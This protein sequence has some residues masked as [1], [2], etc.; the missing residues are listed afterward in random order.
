[1]LKILIALMLLL[2]IL[3]ISINIFC[4]RFIWG[5]LYTVFSNMT[6]TTLKCLTDFNETQIIFQK[7]KIL[8]TNPKSVENLHNLKNSQSLSKTETVNDEDE[9]IFFIATW[10]AKNRKFSQFSTFTSILLFHFYIS[11]KFYSFIH[12]CCNLDERSGKNYLEGNRRSFSYS[13]CW[14]LD[15][16]CS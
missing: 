16:K 9:E 15:V 11:L 13:W 1:M 7:T 6:H 12:L 14:F 4:M 10:S 2:W 5:R 8:P 3:R